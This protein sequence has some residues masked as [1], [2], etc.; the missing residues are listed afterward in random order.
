MNATPFFYN[1]AGLPKPFL[2]R[3][4]FGATFGG[5]IKKDKLFYFVSYQ[6]VRIADAE[7]SLKTLTV[8]TSLTDDRSTQGIINAM[9]SPTSYNTVITAGQINQA[10]LNLLQAKLPNGQY[11]IPSANPSLKPSLGYDAYVQGPNTTSPIDQG[12]ADVDYVVNN[13]DRLSAKYYVQNDPTKNDPFGA[14][15]SSFGFPQ[16]LVAGSQVLPSQIRLYCH[17]T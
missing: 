17:R 14:V 2:N 5:P 11:F 3:N 16:Q 8:P 15:A 9:A 13:K 12:I 1:A 6:G 10:A 4:Q 7:P